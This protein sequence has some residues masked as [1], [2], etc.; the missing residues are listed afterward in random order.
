MIGLAL[1]KDLLSLS[2]SRW[3]SFTFSHLCLFL[4][5]HDF[6]RVPLSHLGNK[7]PTEST[8]KISDG[9]DSDERTSRNGAPTA[10]SS[11]NKK[12][13]PPISYPRSQSN[14]V[15]TSGRLA[16]ARGETPVGSG[17]MRKDAWAVRPGYSSGAS[18]YEGSDGD[19]LG[20][21]DGELYLGGA[22]DNLMVDM[23]ASSDVGQDGAL[24]RSRH[25][26]E[27]GALGLLRQTMFD[28]GCGLTE[29]VVRIE[30]PFGKPIEEIYEGV[31]DGPVLGSGVSGIVRLIQHRATGLKYAVKVLDLGKRD[32]TNV[33][34]SRQEFT[35]HTFSQ[36]ARRLTCI[37][38]RQV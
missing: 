11:F 22:P 28:Q 1:S 3:F 7:F 36:Y 20:V 29:A 37:E 5:S 26:S 6:S 32:L 17:R 24:R 8:K 31:H 14:P 15:P 23:E 27:C 25:G 35:K 13:N 33:R 21:S 18:S 9:E 34:S 38:T 4:P 10:T 30:T 12:S 2:G 16:N 19:E